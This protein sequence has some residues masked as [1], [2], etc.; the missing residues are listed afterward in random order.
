MKPVHLFVDTNVVL[1]FV[2]DRKPFCIESDSLFRMRDDGK[3]VIYISSL[4]LS[5]IS[6]FADKNKLN[7][8]AIIARFLHWFHII[9]LEA[10]F[11]D[12]VLNSK[13]TDFEDGLQ[14]FSAIN[15][16]SVEAIITRNEGDFKYSDIP[17][18]SPANFI[19]N[20]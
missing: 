7:T 4:T 8:K 16:G 15:A 13:F 5:T 19:A 11:F 1:D 14:Y 12:Q 9:D 6:Y 10:S 2:L 3:V 20:Y 17:I 18:I